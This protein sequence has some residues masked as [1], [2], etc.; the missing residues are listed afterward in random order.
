MDFGRGIH[1]IG[2]WWNEAEGNTNL[3][4]FCHLIEERRITLIDT[5]SSIFPDRAIFPY[6][7]KANLDP[8]DI[9]LILNTHG[10]GDHIGGDARVKAVS[11]AKLAAHRLEVPYIEDHPANA[12]GGEKTKVDIILDDGDEIEVA[13]G[14]RLKAIWTPGHSPGSLSFYDVEEKVVF[15]GDSVGIGESVAHLP[16]YSDVEAYVKSMERIGSLEL[17]FLLS[18]HGLP[19]RGRAV[20]NVLNIH[21]RLVREIHKTVLS[22]LKTLSK[23]SSSSDIAKI[24]CERLG[25][26]THIGTIEA[27]LNKLVKE[28]RVKQVM[29]DNNLLWEL[30]E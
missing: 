21:L 15:T 30:C 7:E 23:P 13:D 19:I 20:P 16:Y 24:A 3:F 4:L 14:R 6:M 25:Y 26:P 1:Q 9:S 5:G 22:T 11:G 29:R 17:K 28:D 27:H 18:S 2:G 12:L 10:H 8:R